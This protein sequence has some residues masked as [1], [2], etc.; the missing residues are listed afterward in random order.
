M[1]CTVV[2]QRWDGMG[3]CAL[4][5]LPQDET[6]RMA[7]QPS[8]RLQPSSC[9]LIQTSFDFSR[10]LFLADPCP[11]QRGDVHQGVHSE[12]RQGKAGPEAQQALHR[13][14]V[15]GGAARAAQE[16]YGE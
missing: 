12:L 2:P 7:P 3:C 16:P 6:A 9:D 14:T 10:T 8:P 13:V 5:E 1:D 11:G 15:P 4:N